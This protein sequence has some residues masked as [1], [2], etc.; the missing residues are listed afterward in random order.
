MMD[1]SL[2]VA[3][4]RYAAVN[5]LMQGKRSMDC[6]FKNFINFLKDTSWDSP[7]V[8]SGSELGVKGGELYV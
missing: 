1:S 3:P 2:G 5:K 7:A 4:L 6:S 8:E